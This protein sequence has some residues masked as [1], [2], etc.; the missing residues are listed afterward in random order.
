LPYN[1]DKRPGGEPVV[2][3][4]KV[5]PGHNNSG[6]ASYIQAY[7]TDNS[8]I[9]GMHECNHICKPNMKGKKE[10]KIEY[11]QICTHILHMRVILCM[12]LIVFRLSMVCV[13]W[14]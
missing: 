2:S 12:E 1:V 4:H 9:A 13:I 10:N 7:N 6:M 5:H 14:L 3:D 8:R 11:L